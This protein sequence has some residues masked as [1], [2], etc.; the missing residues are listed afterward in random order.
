MTFPT[1]SESE[2]GLVG[3]G[4][5][6]GI[7]GDKSFIL[8][9]YMSKLHSISFQLRCRADLYSFLHSPF[10]HFFLKKLSSS[11]FFFSSLDSSKKK[12]I[13]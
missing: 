4:G 3:G 7:Q 8:S 2:P 1:L 10:H 13:P 5:G 12:K 9:G 11:T 6:V